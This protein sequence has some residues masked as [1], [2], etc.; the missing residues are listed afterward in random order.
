M[1]SGTDI[2]LY[3]R[4]QTGV[5]ALNRP[6]YDEQPIVIHNVLIGEPSTDDI[7]S[8]YN[9]SGKRIAYM[10]A[11]PKGDTHDWV[12]KVVE[13]YGYRFRTIGIPTQGIEANIPLLWNKKVR[14][15]HYE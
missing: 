12:N 11:I 1:I 14:V 7:L 13:F 9:V 5:D 3:D 8:E 6:I 4:V 10:L 15:E 2:T